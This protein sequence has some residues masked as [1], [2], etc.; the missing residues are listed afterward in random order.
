MPKLGLQA[1]HKSWCFVDA[2]AFG[3]PLE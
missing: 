2:V 3:H 1:V